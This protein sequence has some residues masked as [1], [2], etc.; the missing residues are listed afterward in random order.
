MFTDD[1]YF[2]EFIKLYVS[3][4]IFI[5]LWITRNL[6]TTQT[7][8]IF[9]IQSTVYL[10][11]GF[12]RPS[13]NVFVGGYLTS[14]NVILLQPK[15]TIFS[16]SN[17]VASSKKEVLQE[18]YTGCNPDFSV[19]NFSFSITDEDDNVLDLNGQ[20]VVFSICCYEHNNSLELLKNDI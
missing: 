8:I 2:F 5:H 1:A 13:S 20:D 11:T 7:Q 15:Y 17:I 9:P 16:K 19:I 4:T 12:N 14:A 18:I 10:P 6:T 3:Y